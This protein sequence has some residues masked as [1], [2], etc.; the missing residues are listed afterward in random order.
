[1]ELRPHDV[2][3]GS[4]WKKR[5]CEMSEET[6][7]LHDYGSFRRQSKLIRNAYA[8]CNGEFEWWREACVSGRS[9][10]GITVYE[11][12]LDYD[13]HSQFWYARVSRDW[14][15][16]QQTASHTRSMCRSSLESLTDKQV[17]GSDAVEPGPTLRYVHKAVIAP[18]V[19]SNPDCGVVFPRACV[20]KSCGIAHFCDVC[21]G[22]YRRTIHD[23]KC[24]EYG[25]LPFF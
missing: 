6:L 12:E 1:M 9:F 19:C 2:G 7:H 5:N 3:V 13:I 8:A 14:K 25:A 17:P 10:H 11:D 24:K 4:S 15:S 20:C 18:K 21:S 16:K 22:R 23:P